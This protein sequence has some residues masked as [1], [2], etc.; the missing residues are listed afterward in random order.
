M[1]LKLVFKHAHSHPMS[2]IIPMLMLYHS[3]VCRHALMVSI[4]K[5][6]LIISVL[7]NVHPI[8]LFCST[9][10]PTNHAWVH[11]L[12]TTTPIP[13][14]KCAW[15]HAHQAHHISDTMSITHV[16]KHAQMATSQTNQ[17]VCAYKHARPQ[18]NNMAISPLT[19][20]WINAQ[21]HRICMA[22]ISMM[23]IVHACT[24]VRLVSLLIRWREPVLVSAIWP[25]AIMAIRYRGD[26]CWIVILLLLIIP[27]ANV[28]LC[29]LA[30][31]N[32]ITA[33]LST[34]NAN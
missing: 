31:H 25:M 30:I 7:V 23:G 6:V 32:I 2:H 15:L 12:T 4:R 19:I 27:L 26:A 18:P 24:L 5:L 28:W 20:V 34:T 10:L 3:F 9:F 21:W 17:H 22:K 14:N 1:K 8:L 11:A 29:V 13:V 33:T 16:Y